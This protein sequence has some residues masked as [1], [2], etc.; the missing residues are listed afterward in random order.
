MQGKLFQRCTHLLYCSV[1]SLG[2]NVN[3]KGMTKPDKKSIH[4]SHKKK[5]M[6]YSGHTCLN[7]QNYQNLM[8]LTTNNH[9]FFS[10]HSFM[11]IFHNIL[12]FL[13]MNISLFKNKFHGWRWIFLENKKCRRHCQKFSK[14]EW[15]FSK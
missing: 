9:R 11:L 15:M 13:K 8:F 2:G 4:L 1:P 3:T 10:T 12:Y 7:N 6:K 14:Q 5:S